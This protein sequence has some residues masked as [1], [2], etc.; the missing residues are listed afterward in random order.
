M[1]ELVCRST[2]LVKKIFANEP[3]FR[4]LETLIWRCQTWNGALMAESR[5]AIMADRGQS[6][7]AVWLPLADIG[8]PSQ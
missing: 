3:W 6:P 1:L 8:P 2:T 4:S 5:R 7:A